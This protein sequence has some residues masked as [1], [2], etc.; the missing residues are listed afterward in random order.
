MSFSKP[1]VYPT[2]TKSQPLTS[3]IPLRTPSQHKSGAGA[4]G[5]GGGGATSRDKYQYPEADILSLF[6]NS[7]TGL[8]NNS[9]FNLVGIRGTGKTKKLIDICHKI[10]HL[11]GRIHIFSRNWDKRE[12]DGTISLGDPCIFPTIFVHTEI[13]NDILSQIV[14][15]NE[16]LM[17]PD[18]VL[19]PWADERYKHTLVIIDDML[20]VQ[21]V[22][23]F[24]LS[25]LG[26]GKK[27]RI[28]KVKDTESILTSYPKFRHIVDEGRHMNITLGLSVQDYVKGE[29]H[30]RRNVT[31]AFINEQDSEDDLRVIYK[32][33]FS[34]NFKKFSEFVT[35]FNANTK[36]YGALVK[37]KHK[38]KI[39][40]YHPTHIKPDYESGHLLSKALTN[41]FCHAK[42]S[43]NNSALIKLK[44]ERMIQAVR[45]RD[46]KV[47]KVVEQQQFED[48]EDDEDNENDVNT[49]L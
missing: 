19:P 11:F 9:L 49:S 6:T 26:E 14:T 22:D 5:G 45:D 21:E 15:F 12:D 1:T 46:L 34:R 33:Q 17:S 32:E 23:E 16:Y 8:S 37:S 39:Y 41:L 4:L 40:A 36:N 38:N 44:M 30:F 31:L 27:K 25:S 24:S 28:N 3:F 35:Y 18:S 20:A 48:G 42:G 29:K 2:A 13:S 10:A 43:K 47:Q 7:E